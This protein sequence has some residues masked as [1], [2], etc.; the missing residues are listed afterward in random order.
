[1]TIKIN[2]V[3]YE[4]TRPPLKQ[5]LT[6]ED[7]RVKLSKAVEIHDRE[8]V[9]KQLVSVVS[10]ALSVDK[11][12]L[13][14]RPWYEVA[15]AY[16]TIALLNMPRYEFPFL[17]SKVKD[18][19]DAWDYEGRTWYIWANIFA[20]KYGWDLKTV[21]ELDVDDAIA[22]AQEI[23]VDEQL[24]REWEWMTTEI[25]YQAKE[26]FKPLERPDWMRYT[27]MQQEIP[28]LKIRK[29][30]MPSGVI[31]RYPTSPNREST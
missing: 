4:Y 30:L 31:F 12:T 13:Y 11:E 21:S 5:W 6:L 24:E 18:K 10:T 28:V 15:I 3:G 1:M 7:E 23:A 9:A 26:G 16:Q 25:A 29:D 8:N 2:E 19:K 14:L 20:N 17:T 27:K 22:L